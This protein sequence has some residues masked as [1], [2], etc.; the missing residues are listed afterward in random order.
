MAELDIRA[1][2]FD[3]ILR[4]PLQTTT[5]T[6]QSRCRPL[7]LIVIYL[8]QGLLLDGLRSPA[9]IST[10]KINLK[11]CTVWLLLQMARGDPPHRQRLS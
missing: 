7:K 4:F 1:G 2:P 9:P 11:R 5:A 8:G 6:D 10:S 3:T